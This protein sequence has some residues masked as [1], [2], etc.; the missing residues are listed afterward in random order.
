MGGNEAPKC[1]R[2]V[3]L[4]LADTKAFLGLNQDDNTCA[5]LND[6]IIQLDNVINKNVKLETLMEPAKDAL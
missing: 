6:W 3:L 5:T 1:L 4:E 2:Q